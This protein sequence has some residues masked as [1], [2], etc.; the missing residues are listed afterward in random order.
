[1]TALLESISSTYPKLRILD[2]TTP[3]GDHYMIEL[4]HYHEHIGVTF[5][6]IRD[7]KEYHE[8][9]TTRSLMN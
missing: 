8:K 9:R 1:M 5:T 2:C 4:V 3:F 6:D 7:L